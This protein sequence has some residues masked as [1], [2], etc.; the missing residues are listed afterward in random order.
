M[1]APQRRSANGSVTRSK[2]LPR[3][4]R[5]PRLNGAKSQTI[6]APGIRQGTVIA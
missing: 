1:S 6:A 5:M 3:G 4:V 2:R